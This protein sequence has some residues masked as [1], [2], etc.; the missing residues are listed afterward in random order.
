MNV[1]LHWDRG[2]NFLV[3]WGRI[4]PCSCKVRNIYNGLRPVNQ[5]VYSIPH[6]KPYQPE[7]FPPGVWQIGYPKPRT[8]CY[9]KPWFIPTNAARMA[10]VWETIA[11][12]YVRAT[13]ELTIDED[14]GLHA[15]ASPTTLG[16]I[17]IDTVSDV[18]WMAEQIKRE[19]NNGILYFEVTEHDKRANL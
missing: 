1:A 6:N 19:Y 3:A 18:L 11:G 17:R 13:D 10:K 12:E 2:Q 4:I 8:D 16:C 5:I 14:Y 9:R 15:S 7:V